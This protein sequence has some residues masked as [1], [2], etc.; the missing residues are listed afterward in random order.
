MKELLPSSRKR[1]GRRGG[2][3]SSS[4]PN[5]KK[6]LLHYQQPRQVEQGGF[7]LGGEE[8]RGGRPNYTGL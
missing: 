6:A 7:H 2:K 3:A 8:G 5:P 4:Q 1:G